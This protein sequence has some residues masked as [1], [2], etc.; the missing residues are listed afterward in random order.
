MFLILV[1]LRGRG[2]MLVF[3]SRSVVCPL[4]GLTPF[5]HLFVLFLTT[6]SRHGLPQLQG[7]RTH[8]QEDRVH[9]LCG[10]LLWRTINN[11]WCFNALIVKSNVK[12]LCDWWIPSLRFYYSHPWKQCHYL[13]NFYSVWFS[14]SLM[15]EIYGYYKWC[16]LG[17]VIC[18]HWL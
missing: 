17:L 15:C 7:S 8:S 4:V 14:S 5:S 2:W 13:S 6:H 18:L 3:R 16:L 1:E 12:R 9:V 11:F 10:A